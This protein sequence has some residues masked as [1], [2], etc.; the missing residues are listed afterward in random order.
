MRNLY[1]VLFGLLMCV[2]GFVACKTP[3]GAKAASVSTTA[4]TFSV[5]KLER[6]FSYPVSAREPRFLDSGSPAGDS[7]AYNHR[8]QHWYL[9]YNTNKYKKRYGPLP[10]FYP[11]NVTLDEYKKNPPTVPDE[12]ERI[13]FGNN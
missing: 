11:G 10:R 3:K 7:L 1:L 4:D 5:Y 2:F 8:L 13:M 6:F 9:L 12:Y